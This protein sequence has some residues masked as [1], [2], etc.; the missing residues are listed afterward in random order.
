MSSNTTN[1]TMLPLNVATC[2]DVLSVN[3]SEC[4]PATKIG[5]WDIVNY[6]FFPYTE[7]VTHI[8]TR[9]P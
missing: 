3:G 1:G 8:T 6:D 2:R 9:K 7:S 4:R 5:H